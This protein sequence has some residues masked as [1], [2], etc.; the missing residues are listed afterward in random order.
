MGRLHSTGLYIIGCQHHS[1]KDWK[2]FTNR[3][4][5]LMHPALRYWG[6]IN[7]VS[8]IMDSLKA[9]NLLKVIHDGINHVPN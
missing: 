6:R 4:I 3:Q 5:N 7:Q 9:S 1:N 8:M 2:R